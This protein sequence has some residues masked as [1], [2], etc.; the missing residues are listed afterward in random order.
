[1]RK[2]SYEHGVPCWVDLGSPD[3]EAAAA[4]YCGLFGWVAEGGPPEAGGYQL[5]RYQDAPVAGVGPQQSPGPP[6]WATYVSVGDADD[7]VEKVGANGGKVLMPIIDVMGLGRIAFFADPAGAVI[8]IW[9]P[10]AFPGAELVNEPGTYAWS[11]LITTDL[12]GAK[13]FYGAVFGW[14]H[15]THEGGPVGGYTEW[16]VAGAP[17]AGMMAKPPMMPAEVP[18][19]WGVYFAVAD[20]DA[21]AARARELGGSVPVG[22]LDIEPGRMY[23]LADPTGGHFQIMQLKPEAVGR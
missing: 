8:G 2:T 22:P 3:V 18:P 17:V 13:A 14:G 21:T 4:F 11:E 7:I 9:Q 5:F 16:K 6:V 1:M 19:H 12:D 15:E 10:L 23:V 20:A